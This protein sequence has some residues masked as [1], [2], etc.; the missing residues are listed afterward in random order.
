M[1][2]GPPRGDLKSV[3]LQRGSG[4]G[5]RGGHCPE[6][7]EPPGSGSAG[8]RGCPESAGGAGQTSPSPRLEA[9][10][11]EGTPGHLLPV[12]SWWLLRRRGRKHSG[13]PRGAGS[14]RTRSLHGEKRGGQCTGL[15]T[16][17]APS[18]AFGVG[19]AAFHQRESRE[20][21]CPLP[22]S[23]RGSIAGRQ[24]QASWCSAPSFS[25]TPSWGGPWTPAPS[26]SIRSHIPSPAPLGCHLH[27]QPPASAWPHVSIS[28][29]GWRTRPGE[30]GG[31]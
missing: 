17:W 27:C 5:S 24:S 30:E 13:L 6:S 20:Q 10:A 9:A 7:P 16:A 18:P 12:L 15:G 21:P 26:S 25:C 31:G 28:L 8:A 29:V 23:E 4:K 14:S 19:R 3:T 1:G 11:W 2:P 22:S